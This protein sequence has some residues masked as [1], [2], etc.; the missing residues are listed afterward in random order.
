MIEIPKLFVAIAQWSACVLHISFFKKRFGKIP[1][2]ACAILW[3]AIIVLQQLLCGYA[4]PHALL[5]AVNVAVSLILMSA[6]IFSC[7][8]IKLQD[9]VYYGICSVIVS[10]FIASVEWQLY[11]YFYMSYDFAK[12]AW[13]RYVWL[14]FI[15]SA[16]FALLCVINVK[17]FKN[18]QA[19]H[20]SGKD[21]LFVFVVMCVSLFAANIKFFDNAGEW[22]ARRIREGL[23]I[24]TLVELCGI[25]VLYSNRVM[26]DR[27]MYMTELNA[28]RQVMDNQYR[29]Y[30]IY[31]ENDE[32]INRHYHD[33]KHQ[34]DMILSEEDGNKRAEYLKDIQNAIRI[35]QSEHKTGNEVV[36]V[37]LSGKNLECVDGGITMSVVADGKL[38]DFMSK[39]DICSVL[40]NCLDNAIESVRKIEDQ[41]KRIIQFALFTQGDMIVMRVKNYCEEKLLIRDG[42]IVTSKNHKDDHGYGLKSIRFVAEKYGGN[43]KILKEGNWFSLCLLFPDNINETK[44]D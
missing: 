21:I 24:R 33:L 39:M 41:E 36:D 35:R 32:I 7:T 26:C 44:R 25:F 29:Q 34:L 4:P 11:N 15:D 14:A 3:L 20:V 18:S 30:K 8:E 40:G 42:E 38:L 1:V 13:F 9:A 37:I 5:W 28:T 22:T 16:C 2:A 43:M 23:E 19:L 27:I 6:F 31:K 10:E 12:E 17:L